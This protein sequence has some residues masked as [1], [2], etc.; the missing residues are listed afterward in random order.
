[1]FISFENS[2]ET[3]LYIINNII[4]FSELAVRQINDQMLLF[5]RSFVANED[6]VEDDKTR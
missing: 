1:M 4:I 3:N 2:F 5:E 6:L